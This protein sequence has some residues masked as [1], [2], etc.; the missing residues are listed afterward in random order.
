ME[1]IR[2]LIADDHPVI[3]EG[4]SAMLSRQPDFMILGEAENGK[5]AVKKARQLRPDIV[6]MDLRMPEM[7]GVEAMK[8]I[9]QDNPKTKFIILT[10]Y[11]DGDYIFK[12]IEAGARAYLLKDAKREDVYNAI[13][14]VH[15]GGSILQPEITAKVL[16]RF[17]EI[18]QQIQEPE[19]LSARELEILRLIAKGTSNKEIASN[20]GL[21]E[22]TVKTHVHNIFHRLGVNDRAEA[23]A[24]AIKRG[25]ISP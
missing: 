22:S 11:K 3:R 16:D 21:Y 13:R 2:I 4:L 10:T 9:R 5:D 18:S 7:D 12:G 23:V 19:V 1:K 24:Q 20:L 14:I 8:R 25:L 15:E 6:L 17:S